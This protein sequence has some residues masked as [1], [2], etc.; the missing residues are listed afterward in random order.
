MKYENIQ[1]DEGLNKEWIITNGIGGYASSTIIRCKH[2]EISWSFSSATF[3][4]RKKK[5]NIIKS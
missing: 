3:T 5:L 4:T 1:L 2:K